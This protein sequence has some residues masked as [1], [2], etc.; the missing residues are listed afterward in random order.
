MAGLRGTQGLDLKVGEPPGGGLE[1]PGQ[2]FAGQGGHCLGSRG[3]LPPA[4]GVRSTGRGK[5]LSLT[6]SFFSQAL[7]FLPFSWGSPVW[8][9]ICFLL[10]GGS[11]SGVGLL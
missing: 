11:T 2:G 7:G 3:C 6:S 10:I 4:L 5:A 8:G 1:S 9:G